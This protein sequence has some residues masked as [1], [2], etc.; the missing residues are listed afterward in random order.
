MFCIYHES[1]N[2]YFNVATDEYILKH[3]DEDCFMPWRNDN[4]IIVGNTKI[5][6]RKS[7]TIMYIGIDDL[8]IALF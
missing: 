7:I 5:H 4:A 1:T 6:R 2:P 3:M 8:I